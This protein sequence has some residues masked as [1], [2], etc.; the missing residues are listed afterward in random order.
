MAEDSRSNQ[1]QRLFRR[2]VVRWEWLRGTP[3][4]VIAFGVAAAVV[5]LLWRLIPTRLNVTT[6]ALGYPTRFNFNIFRQWYI[7]GLLV[8]VLPLSALGAYALL[9]RARRRRLRLRDAEP[10]PAGARPETVVGDAPA[11][12]SAL[13]LTARHGIRMLGVG[14]VLALE[15]SVAFHS[16]SPSATLVF[17]GISVGYPLVSV[18]V[19]VAV[20]RWARSTIHLESS[21][22]LLN[23]CGAVLCVIGLYVVSRATQVSITSAHAV[24]TVPWLPAWLAFVFVVGAVAGPFI[25][26]RAGWSSERIWNSER[27]MILL[28]AV[29]SAF[30]V[31]HAHLPGQLGP[32]SSFE[33]GQLLVG[34]HQVL[35]GAFPWRDIILAHGIFGDALS[36]MP[37]LALVELSRWGA[38]VGYYL[39]VEPV[40]WLLLYGLVLYLTRAKWTYAIVF[41]AVIV[42]DTTFLGGFLSQVSIRF[43]PLPLVVGAFAVLLRR[44]SWPRA[45]VFTG[46]LLALVVL[47]PEALVLVPAFA[48]V[49]VVFELYTKPAGTR[50]GRA[51]L[52]RLCRCAVS[53]IVWL[54]VLVAWLVAN[55]ALDGFIF[56]FKTFVPAHILEGIPVES[57]HQLLFN[58]GMYVPISLA[59]LYL[60]ALATALFTRHKPRLEDWVASVLALSAILY[61]A[62]FLGRPDEG[63]LLQY[64]AFATPFMIY[65]V[66]RLVEAAAAWFAA[67]HWRSP[68]SS[69][70]GSYAVAGILVVGVLAPSTGNLVDAVQRAP[71]HFLA[72]AKSPPA[73]PR[74]GYAQS[75]VAT[76]NEFNDLRK[77]LGVLLGTYQPRVWD[78]SNSPADVYFFAQLKLVTRY[79]N[80][81]IAIEPATQ[82]DVISELKRAHPDI[83]VYNSL[84]GLTIWDGLPNMVRHYD[85]SAWILRNYRPVLD[86]AGYLLF[87]RKSSRVT[88][89]SLSGLD[90]SAPIATSNLYTDFASPCDWGY[91]PNFFAQHPARTS[92]SQAVSLQGLGSHVIV[93]GRLSQPPDVGSSAVGVF[94]TEDGV[95]V[96][97]G[98]I[99]PTSSLFASGVGYGFEVDAPVLPGRPIGDLNTW[100]RTANGSIE[101]LPKPGER[102]VPAIGT[103]ENQRTVWEDRLTVPANAS[104]LHWLE[105][106]NSTGSTIAPDDFSLSLVNDHAHGIYFSTRADAPR[107]FNVRLDN[108]TQWAVMPGASAVLVHN[109]RQSQLKLRFRG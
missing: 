46:S 72:T 89:A 59:L 40:Y 90:V 19:S 52:P 58:A 99:E 101:Q 63:H 5:A 44:S 35:Q 55:D 31:L 22:S 12:N 37:G 33:E 69:A 67:R 18:A 53:G 66:Y 47:T 1:L 98:R 57:T 88:A 21:L 95:Q 61:Y 10:A 107:P 2:R 9:T 43:L 83:I 38:W 109:Q 92:V 82:Q 24:R 29:P 41:L 28:V 11:G 14:L 49:L 16:G 70:F 34:A 32:Y 97:T 74:V 48:G 50:F 77:I 8:F 23:M 102:P 62:K 75:G 27:W 80:V 79:D 85:V 51:A 15:A 76:T 104:N 87:A 106:T 17:V 86:Y 103:I 96:G 65:A 6:N 39:L 105:L 13:R 20:S 68:L 84:R 45:A 100:V 3:Y 25:Y 60:A 108:C 73:V 56:Y 71:V 7:F 78:F 93:E 4:V 64:L 91:V 36:F 94:V 81:S 26:L 42:L 54:L 30:F